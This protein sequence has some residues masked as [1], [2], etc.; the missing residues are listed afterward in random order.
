M[1]LS[2]RSEGVLLYMCGRVS[3]CVCVVYV[4]LHKSVWMEMPCIVTV[5]LSVCSVYTG[6][7]LC[8]ACK[9]LC[10]LTRMPV[11]VYTILLFLYTALP[12]L[13]VLWLPGLCINQRNERDSV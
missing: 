6:D 5:H 12:S 9:P 10:F 4:H 2:L 11:S 13:L 1:N 8:T 7:F 3:L